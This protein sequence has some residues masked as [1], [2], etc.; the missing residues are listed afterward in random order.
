MQRAR[1]AWVC[2][3]LAPAMPTAAPA[4]ARDAGREWNALVD[5]YLEKVY[6]P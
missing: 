5:E 1:K 2:L 3:M 6:F 4:L